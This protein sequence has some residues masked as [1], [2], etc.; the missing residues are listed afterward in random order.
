[1]RTLN[2][3]LKALRPAL[4]AGLTALAVACAS[5]P[6]YLTMIVEELWE[7]GT[8]A[9]E[10]E[11]WD[12]AIEV[13]QRLIVENPGHPRGPEARMLVGRS[14]AQ[15]GEYVTAASEFERFLQL[16]RNHGL[17]PEASLGI[18][19]AYAELAPHPQRDQTYTRQAEEA[20]AQ[21]WLEFRGLTVAET[22]D[23]IRLVMENRLAER[24]FQATLG[25]TRVRII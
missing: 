12:H 4:A 8:R 10:E 23:S 18:C 24:A 11:D 1:M 2:A 6:A 16:Y 9:Y 17:A 25:L 22:A 14:F 19:Q 15:R 21:T 13:L 20:C 7:E 5:V 3:A